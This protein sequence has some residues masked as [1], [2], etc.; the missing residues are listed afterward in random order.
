[1]LVCI[2]FHFS[3]SA[4]DFCGGP[5]FGQGLRVIKPAAEIF[6]VKNLPVLFYV[7]S[8]N[9]RGILRRSTELSI[10]PE[11]TWQMQEVLEVHRT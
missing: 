2:F 11:S 4:C 7:C 8:Q 10:S 1:M 5:K 6:G 9:C 3:V